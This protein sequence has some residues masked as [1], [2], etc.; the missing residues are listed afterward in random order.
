MF[1][2]L[3]HAVLLTACLSALAA[4]SAE[5]GD[6]QAA[7]PGPAQ[8]LAR[9]DLPKIR[10]GRWLMRNVQFEGDKAS[11]ELL[12]EEPEYVCIPAGADILRTTETDL[13]DCAEHALTRRGGTIVVEAQCTAQ[14]V[15]SSIR[16]VYSGDFQSTVHADVA[17]GLA[18]VGQPLERIR[19]RIEG[20][21]QG[22]CQ[23]DE[24]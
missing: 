24:G 12:D 23:G 2:P 10:P 16:A 1:R 9:T 13:A 14:G 3:T 5:Q 22:A 17:L 18:P 19:V 8:A 4:C 11:R 6:A 20:R 15:K 21:Y 7:S